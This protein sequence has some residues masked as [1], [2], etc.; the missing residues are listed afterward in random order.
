MSRPI[1]KKQ[2]KY[3]KGIK[4]NTPEQEMKISNM[5]QNIL[6]NPTPVTGRAY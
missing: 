3:N 1:N 6:S 2:T 4:I 5:F